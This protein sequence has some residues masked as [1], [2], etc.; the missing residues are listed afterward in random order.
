[1]ATSNLMICADGYVCKIFCVSRV[2]V[3]LSFFLSFF[4]VYHGMAEEV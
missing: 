1:M 4:L 3:Y 2:G